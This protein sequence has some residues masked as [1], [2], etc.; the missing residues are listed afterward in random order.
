MVSTAGWNAGAAISKFH[1]TRPDGFIRMKWEKSRAVFKSEAMRKIT[2]ILLG[3]FWAQAVCFAEIIHLKDGRIINEKIVERGRYYIVTM[4]G[5]M[6]KKYYDGEIDFIEEEGQRSSQEPGAIDMSKFAG[7]PE[8]K[9]RLIMV[10]IDVS[11]VR[12]NMELN[13]E[14]VLKGVEEAKKEKF[15]ELFKVSDIIDRIVPIYNNFYTHEEL[16][17]IIEFYESPAG[18]KVVESTPKIMQAVVQEAAKYFQEKLS[19]P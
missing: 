6:P 15:K 4:D 16:V 8:D 12:K 19:L 13:I 10:L 7:L 11:G 3:V 1:L 2:L 5:V 18:Q 17:K 14:Q 9:V